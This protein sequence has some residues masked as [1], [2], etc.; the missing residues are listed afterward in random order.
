MTKKTRYQATTPD[1]RHTVTRTSAR[2][3]TCALAVH[4]PYV[5]GPII[6]AGPHVTDAY[7]MPAQEEGWRIMSFHGTPEGAAEWG[8]PSSGCLHSPSSSAV[9][10]GSTSSRSRFSDGRTLFRRDRGDERMDGLRS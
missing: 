8:P 9:V 5:L 3:Y 6:P 4:H 2:E 10:I 7:R 1:G